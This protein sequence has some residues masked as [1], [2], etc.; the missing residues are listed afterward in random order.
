[1]Y[2]R[3]PPDV[4]PLDRLPDSTSEVLGYKVPGTFKLHEIHVGRTYQPKSLERYGLIPS[5]GS[6]FLLPDHLQFDCWKRHTSGA[7]DVL[8]RLVWHEPSVTIRT[9]FFKP[10]KGRYLHPEWSKNDLQ[11]NRALTHAEAAVI[12]GLD[13]RHVWT[14]SKVEIA[15]QIGNA[16][17]PP[18]ALAVARQ[19]KARLR[20]G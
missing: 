8:G 15:R 2:D 12:Q 10:E 16:V 14:G 5:G 4:A 9:E 6:R 3:F 1:M 13:D 19:V 11:I 20:T 17:P 7:S 18:L